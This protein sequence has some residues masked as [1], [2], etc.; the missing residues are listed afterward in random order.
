MELKIS[1]IYKNFGNGGEGTFSL[2]VG[3]IIVELGRVVFLMGHNG[4]G[5]SVLL[6][7]MAGE[8]SPSKGAITFQL[9]KQIWQADGDPCSIVRQKADENLASDLSVRE[10]LLLRSSSH[11]WADLLF[12]KYRLQ[13]HVQR[14][15]ENHP[16]LLE[17][18]DQPCRTLSVG[19]RQT[20]AFLA[21]ASRDTKVLLLD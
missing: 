15:L 6:K 4:S 11:K 21:V 12:P 16:V 9:G 10:N 8:M 2:S 7:L 1:G 13:S 17:K 5:K 20:L 19:Q 3:D 18:I 14:L